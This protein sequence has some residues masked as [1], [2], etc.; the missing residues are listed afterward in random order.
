MTRAPTSRI[1]AAARSAAAHQATAVTRAI[2]VLKLLAA[3]SEPMGV[4]AIPRELGMAPS[5][6]GGH[7]ISDSRIS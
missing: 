7:G 3:A 5:S 2:R 1:P 6:C 4:N